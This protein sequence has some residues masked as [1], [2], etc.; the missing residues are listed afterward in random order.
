MKKLHLP[1]GKKRKKTSL[2]TYLLLMLI[3]VIIVFAGT[4]LHNLFYALAILT[5]EVFILTK[6]MD[7][8]EVAFFIAA[9]IM[10]PLGFLIGLV[11]SILSF[12][13]K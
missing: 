11:G 1:F 2:K 13:K 4:I 5:K 12:F 7:L 8:L 10:A 3:S 9:T 6:L